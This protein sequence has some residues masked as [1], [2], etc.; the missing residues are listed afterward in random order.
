MYLEQPGFEWTSVNR[1]QPDTNLV[2]HV[3]FHPQAD[4]CIP[5]LNE[6][7][8]ILFLNGKD[9][10]QCSNEQVVSAIRSIGD[11]ASK[12]LLLTVRPNGKYL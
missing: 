5:R 11:A 10:T 8:Q 6:G 2:A 3:I 7:D 12:D 4:Q 9:M 1:F